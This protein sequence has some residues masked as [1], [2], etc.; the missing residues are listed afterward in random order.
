MGVYKNYNFNDYNVLLDI[1]KRDK[2]SFIEGA[3]TEHIFFEE[4]MKT[5]ILNQ[6]NKA[7]YSTGWWRTKFRNDKDYTLFKVSLNKPCSNDEKIGEIFSDKHNVYFLFIDESNKLVIYD[8][9]TSLITPLDEFMNKHILEFRDD[10]WANEDCRIE[11]RQSRAIEFLNKNNLLKEYA[12]QRFFVNFILGLNI[13]D[14]VNIDG[15]LSYEENNNFLLKVVEIKFKYPTRDNKFGLNKGFQN[16]FNMMF[17][18]NIPVVHY[19]LNNATRSESKSIID[20]LTDSEI[21]PKCSWIYSG[22]TKDLLD[23]E[24]K[25]AP[26]K[27]RYNGES[28]HQKYIPVDASKFRKIKDL[29]YNYSSN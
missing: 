6:L 21:K 1:V 9:K 26:S 14:L 7:N 19:I 17:E 22:I 29:E 20:V 18:Y 25:V 27:T 3:C 12:F 8:I 28:N 15:I 11:S 5:R 2:H 4:I 23:S 13:V 24:Y 16:L 10:Y